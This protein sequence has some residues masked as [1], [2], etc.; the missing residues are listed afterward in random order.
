L[1]LEQ[2][3]RG[4]KINSERKR[5]ER[6]FGHTDTEERKKGKMMTWQDGCFIRIRGEFA[7]HTPLGFD[8]LALG[9]LQGPLGP[10]K[11]RK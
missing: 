1:W 6:L 3:K 8:H 5:C 9:S 2:R 7:N 4:K 11:H 10:Y